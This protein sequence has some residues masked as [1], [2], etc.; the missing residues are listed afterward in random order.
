MNRT[1]VESFDKT[2]QK[3]HITCPLALREKYP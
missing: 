2:L 3:T 1:E